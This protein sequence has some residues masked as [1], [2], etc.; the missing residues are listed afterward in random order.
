MQP[1]DPRL[2]YPL[3]VFMK[4]SGLGAAALR[5]ARRN[6]LRILR[7]GGRAFVLGSEFQRYL[8]EL[9]E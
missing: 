4:H 8:E 2:L 6:G 9:K 7:T 1:I 3:D 5:K